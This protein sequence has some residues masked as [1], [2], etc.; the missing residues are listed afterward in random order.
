[1][2][3]FDL[4][5]IRRW[6]PDGKMEVCPKTFKGS[7][8]RTYEQIVNMYG[9]GEY[10]LVSQDA[11]THQFSAWS[12]RM[13]FPGPSKPFVDV[14]P[15]PSPSPAHAPQGYYGAPSPYPAAGGSE[16]MVA[17]MRVMF[18]SNAAVLKLLVD[19]Q[20]GG[21]NVQ[22]ALVSKLLERLLERQAQNPLELLRDTVPLLQALN[23]G[24]G[25]TKQFMQGVEFAKEV[26]GTGGGTSKADDLGELASLIKTFMTVKASAA[27][28]NAAQ[29]APTSVSSGPQPQ[30]AT[31]PAPTRPRKTRKSQPSPTSPP[32]FPAPFS[33]WPWPYLPAH[34]YGMMHPAYQAWAAAY[35]HAMG[36]NTPV[37]PPAYPFA[38]QPPTASPA[39][40]ASVTSAVSVAPS[41]PQAAPASP[42]PA[43]E[44]ATMTSAP[45]VGDDVPAPAAQTELVDASTVTPAVAE[46]ALV[47]PTVADEDL[48]AV[49]PTVVAVAGDPAVAD[50][51]LDVANHDFDP[52]APLRAIIAGLHASAPSG[53]L[54]EVPGFPVPFAQPPGFPAPAPFAPPPGFPASPPFDPMTAFALMSGGGFPLPLSS[55]ADPPDDD[56]DDDDESDD[57]GVEESATTTAVPGVIAMA[58]A[59][60]AFEA[61]LPEELRPML[62]ALLGKPGGGGLS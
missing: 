1:M 28:T 9:G 15:A 57:E 31:Q 43:Q 39:P 4:I 30:P 48:A 25:N 47:A 52:L 6:G 3:K 24:G 40:A 38:P 54:A 27:P 42:D 23:G 33:P 49:T 34:L 56:D 18:E 62:R 60:P 58:A 32:G 17:M 8:L 46:A 35:A 53:P 11:K 14:P 21:S 37:V 2:R 45:T 51:E 29:Q 26:L 16:M 12:D 7:E 20:D 50:E 5:Q 36:G 59:D 41:A 55:T 19:R 61:A 10:Q 13:R 44:D 22:T